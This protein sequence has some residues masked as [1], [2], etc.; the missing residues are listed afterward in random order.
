[1]H[2]T[3]TEKYSFA[4]RAIIFL[5]A[6]ILLLPALAAAATH[7]LFNLQSS[8]TSPFPSDRFTVFDG[9]QLTEEPFTD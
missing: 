6:V 1:M 5:A 9:Q 4:P 3:L 7:P 8:A 2:T